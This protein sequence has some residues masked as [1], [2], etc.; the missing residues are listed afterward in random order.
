MFPKKKYPEVDS[1][2]DTTCTAYMQVCCKADEA[3]NSKTYVE[4][5]GEAQ[6]IKPHA[7]ARRGTPPAQL[8]QVKFI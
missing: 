7:L 8:Q 6:L 1:I 2:I 4:R 5:S 3:N